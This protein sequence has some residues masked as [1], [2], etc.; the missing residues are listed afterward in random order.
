MEV[1]REFLDQR[2]ISTNLWPPQSPD[3][4]PC[5]FFLWGYIKNNVY[6][7]SPR[8][9]EELKARIVEEITKIDFSMLK[10]IFT[11][12]LKRCNTCITANG[13]HFQHCV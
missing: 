1:L 12:L 9:L 6:A 3:L 5:D 10:R 13:Q 4:T 8:T 11:N 7:T 2:L